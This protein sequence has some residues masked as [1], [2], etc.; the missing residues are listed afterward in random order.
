MAKW[1]FKTKDGK[2]RK[3]TVKECRFILRTGGLSY[4]EYQ[5]YIAGS[6]KVKPV[7]LKFPTPGSYDWKKYFDNACIMYRGVY[8]RKQLV[9]IFNQFAIAYHGTH[10]KGRDTKDYISRVTPAKRTRECRGT[11]PDPIQFT[12]TNRR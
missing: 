3:P 12:G 4:K 11:R 10:N 1:D 6:A 7:P 5:R 2:F 8:T 9:I